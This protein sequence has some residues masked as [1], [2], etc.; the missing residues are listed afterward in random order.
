MIR[1]Q[2]NHFFPAKH[3]SSSSPLATIN[4]DSDS[5]VSNRSMSINGKIKERNKKPNKMNFQ[6]K[7][8]IDLANQTLNVNKIEKKNHL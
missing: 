7:I 4:E 1:Q 2:I 6:L 3:S 8:F 5:S